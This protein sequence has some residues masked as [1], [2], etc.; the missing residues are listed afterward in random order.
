M[1]PPDREI[2]EHLV[3]EHHASLSRLAIRM[4]GDLEP[5]EEIMQEALLR[6]VN[7]WSGFRGQSTFRTWATRILL[8][9]FHDWLAKR[10][11]VRADGRCLRPAA[12]G[13]RIVRHGR[14]VAAIRCPAGLGLAA[15]AAEV[16]Y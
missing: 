12:S 5:A 3:S 13:P 11:P 10:P 15:A 7:G 9:V 6:I 8:N 14:G 1:S 4:T 2:L 16:L